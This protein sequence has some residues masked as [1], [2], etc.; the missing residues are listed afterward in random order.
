MQFR[1]SHSLAS[2]YRRFVKD[3]FTLVAPF[4]ELVKKDVSFIYSRK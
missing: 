2:F 4:N 3:F 1:L